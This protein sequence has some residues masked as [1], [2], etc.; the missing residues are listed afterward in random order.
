ML[1]RRRQSFTRIAHGFGLLAA[2]VFPLQAVMIAD[3]YVLTA[4]HCV[5]GATSWSV[6]F[7]TALG[8]TTIG[9]SGTYLNPNFAPYP[10]PGPLQGLDQYDVA[11]LRLSSAAPAGAT[12]Y[13]IKTDYSGITASTALDLVGYGLGGSP[14]QP[15]NSWPT[16]VRRHA[17]E[18][19]FAVVNGIN[20][21]ATPDN[22]IIMERAFNAST[23]SGYGL[24]NGGDSGGPMFF[25]NQ[26]LGVASFGNLPGWGST[27]AFDTTYLTGHESLATAANALFVEEFLVPE[28]GTW[29][30]LAGGGAVLLRRR[31]D[32]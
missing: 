26:I 11:V 23:P 8:S 6:T 13:G 30:L 10:N 2:V 15:I 29:L 28:P 3:R 31:R 20:G 12:R 4:G 32:V 27:Y 14:G 1:E 22:P 18:N 24:I 17:V 9:V 19:I 25:G 5:D 21:Q 16:G 7:Q